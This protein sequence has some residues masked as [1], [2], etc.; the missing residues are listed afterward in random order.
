MIVD[1]VNSPTLNSISVCNCFWYGLDPVSEGLNPDP[2]L[3]YN[4]SDPDRGVFSR[5]SSGSDFP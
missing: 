4:R 1:L 5:V 3:D 2:Y